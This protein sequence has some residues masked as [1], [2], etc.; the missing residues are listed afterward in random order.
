MARGNHP[1]TQPPPPPQQASHSQNQF[2]VLADAG[3]GG[4]DAANQ[5]E[6]VRGAFR[7]YII[8]I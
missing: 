7:S 5:S 4:N 2:Q 1:K 3:S 8:S 6:N